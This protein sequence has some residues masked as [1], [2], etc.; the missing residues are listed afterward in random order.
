LRHP[1]YAY[2]TIHPEDLFALFFLR[3]AQHSPA[4]NPQRAF[5]KQMSRRN[6]SRENKAHPG[7]HPPTE[8]SRMFSGSKR[9]KR[10][11]APRA[12]FYF[13]PHRRFR[14]AVIAHGS[15]PNRLLRYKLH[16]AFGADAA[17]VQT[18]VV[19]LCGRFATDPGSHH[20]SDQEDKSDPCTSS[21]QV[22][23]CSLQ[24]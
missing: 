19:S 3:R 1:A 13:S 14:T 18:P 2:L 9:I 8:S 7:A 16:R 22:G 11:Q 15:K 12:L 20:R 21:Y 4:A 5:A 10:G 23:H 24:R 17:S 6:S